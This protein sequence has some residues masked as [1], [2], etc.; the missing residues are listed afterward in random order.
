M[1]PRK[2]D[3]FG[4]TPAPGLLTKYGDLIV[5]TPFLVMG[6]WAW[7]NLRKLNKTKRRKKKTKIKRA[8]KVSSRAV[9]VIRATTIPMRMFKDRRGILRLKTEDWVAEQRKLKALKGK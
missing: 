2:L 1:T 7:N 6:L 9:R 8:R 5:A 3:G 4:E